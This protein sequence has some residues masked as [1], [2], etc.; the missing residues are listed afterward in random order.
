MNG[1]EEGVARTSGRGKP[2][3]TGPLRR[4]RSPTVVRGMAAL[5]QAGAARG[6][7][8]MRWEGGTL[9]CPDAYLVST[10]KDSCS[11]LCSFRAAM[12]RGVHEGVV[13]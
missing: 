3:R 6:R 5:T 10:G 7:F 4:Y 11:I 12:G 2:R 1:A 9:S 13:A 8:H